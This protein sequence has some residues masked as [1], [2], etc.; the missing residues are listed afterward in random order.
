V[1]S[2]KA[3]LLRRGTLRGVN[4][5]LA[6]WFRVVLPLT[7][8]G[9]EPHELEVGDCSGALMPDGVAQVARI[10]RV[11]AAVGASGLGLMRS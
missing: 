5:A 8:L 10:D 4:T 7:F 1:W 2:G 6:C 11:D 3:R 9:S